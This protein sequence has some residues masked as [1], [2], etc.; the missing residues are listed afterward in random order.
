MF[1]NERFEDE[2]VPD[3]PNGKIVGTKEMAR[4]LEQ[5]KSF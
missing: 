4:I 3:E 5:N 1:Q 2:Y